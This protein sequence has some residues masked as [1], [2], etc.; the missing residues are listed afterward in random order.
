MR[1]PLPLEVVLGDEEEVVEVLP[2]DL[3]RQGEGGPGGE[4]L[5]GLYGAA[6]YIAR[7][8]KPRSARAE[9]EAVLD[10]LINGL[11]SRL[12]QTT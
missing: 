8:A 12:D 4:A 7:S 9:V 2:Q 1:R 11:R 6:L 5:G 10:T 3:L